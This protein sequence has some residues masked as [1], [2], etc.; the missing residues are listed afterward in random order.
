MPAADD[1]TETDVRRI[2]YAFPLFRYPVRWVRAK[3]QMHKPLITPSR[4]TL[5][6]ATAPTLNHYGCTPVMEFTVD[7]DQAGRIFRTSPGMVDG[8]VGGHIHWTKSQD[9]DQSGNKVKWQ[10]EYKTWNG[11]D[12]NAAGAGLFK[13]VEDTYLSS[14]TGADSRIVYKAVFIG[15]ESIPPNTYISMKL[16]AITPSSDTLAEPALVSLDMTWLEWKNIP[17]L[18]NAPTISFHT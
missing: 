12:E 2:E 9:S 10:V 4:M 6:A 3:Q 1:F 14:A 17:L 11:H 5:P 16:S 18:N 13:T 8:T 15:D 7:T